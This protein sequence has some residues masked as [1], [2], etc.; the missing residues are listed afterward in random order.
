MQRVT[1]PGT[2]F[3]TSRFIFGTAALL[4]SGTVRM[5]QRLLH[6]AVE[7]GFTH[8]DTAPYYGFG[9]AE[10]DLAPVLASNPQVS[11]TT[12]VGIYSPGGEMQPGLVIVLRKVGGKIVPALSR[13]TVDWNVA[14]AEQSLKGS[15]RRLGR[16]RIELFMLHEPVSALLRTDEW[17]RWLEAKVSAGDVG[18]FGLALHT[19]RI[20]PFLS[21]APKLSELMQT[22][23]S[24][25]Q[26][27]AD[28]LS[29]YGRPRQITYGYVSAA[30]AAGSPLPVL[31][32]LKR[33]LGLNPN[34]AIIVSTRR[35]K[36]LGQYA[37][38][39]QDI[40]V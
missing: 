26:K 1:I 21:G 11:I 34:G 7:E 38:L 3:L 10:R 18:R 25:E 20:E 6:A 2:D 32:I 9:M 31:E 36:R 29:R 12:K 16:K 19:D 15:L 40:S 28:I 5:R 33:A 37:R 8:F 35:R 17:L 24:I 27:E 14:R 39:L 13:R 22:F 4:N 23:D 30:R